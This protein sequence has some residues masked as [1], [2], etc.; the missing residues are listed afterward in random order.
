MPDPMTSSPPRRMRGLGLGAAGVVLGVGSC[1][2][3]VA[4]L[5]AGA[6]AVFGAVGI[7]A[8]VPGAHTIAPVAEPML[9]LSILLLVVGMA[10][11]GRALIVTAVVGG[12]L[13]Y[14]SMYLFN[15]GDMADMNMAQDHSA[16]NAPAFYLGLAL[17]AFTLGWSAVRRYRHACRHLGRNRL[18]TASDR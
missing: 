18:D 16:T 9:I 15:R 17:L 7:T 4:A 10:R 6:A 8:T 5:P 13:V 14:A 1:V 2:P 12:A 11:C 3:M